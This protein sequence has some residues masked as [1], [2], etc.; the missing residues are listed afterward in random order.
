MKHILMVIFRD[1]EVI[2]SME[3]FQERLQLN[4]KVY[5]YSQMNKI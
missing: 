1:K 2:L 4:K 5:F 3:N